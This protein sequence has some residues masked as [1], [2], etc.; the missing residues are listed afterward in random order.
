MSKMT[1][2][3]ARADGA[4]APGA[5]VGGVHYNQ[6]GAW[7][8]W[9][10]AWYFQ[11]DFFQYQLTK[12]VVRYRDKG[13]IRD[14]QKAQHFLA[15]YIEVLEAD[16]TPLLDAPDPAATEPPPPAENL[17]VLYSTG[18]EGHDGKPP[19]HVPGPLLVHD[20]AQRWYTVKPE[21]LRQFDFDAMVKP[22]GWWGFVFEGIMSGQQLF[23]CNSCREHVKT[24]PGQAPY[25]VHTCPGRDSG[26]PG[27]SYVNQGGR[28][29]AKA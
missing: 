6:F 10:M 29:E 17:G 27:P 7:Q 3:G 25:A 9:D 4:N 26:E 28:D 21:T 8:H 24:A 2:P 1:P 13:G 20:S 16:A 5:Q 12:Y 23:R 18:A 19:V 14:L 22:T 15:K 11:L